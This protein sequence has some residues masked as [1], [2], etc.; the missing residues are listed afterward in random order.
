MFLP[1]SSVWVKSPMICGI[2][3]L[4]PVLHKARPGTDEGDGHRL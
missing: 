2:C 1:D 3:F 4:P